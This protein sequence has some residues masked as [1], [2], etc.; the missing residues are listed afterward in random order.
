MT[1]NNLT[2]G[3]VGAGQMGRG[4][5]QVCAMAGMTVLLNDVS[6]QAVARGIDT[7][8]GQLD[9]LVTK[10]KLSASA[11][12]EALRHLKP[13]ASLEQLAQCD[14]VIEAATE[15][16]ALKLDI[17]RRLDAIVQPNAVLASNTSSIS[18]TRIAAATQRP[19]KVIGMHFMNP[20]PVMPLIEV[21][22]GLHTSDAVCQAVTLLAKQIGKVPVEVKDGFGFVANRLLIPM[23]NEAIFCLHEG[24]ASAEDIDTVMKLGANHPI[25]PLA[26]ADLIG[27]DTCLAIMAVLHEGF[28]DSKYRPCPLLKQMVDAGLLG[29]KTGQGFF[30]YN[31]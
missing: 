17:F 28:D 20:V 22:R 18:I 7:I 6:E 13:A 15:N 5:A 23:I 9:R 14:C 30:R 24:L 12:D 4:I 8:A 29:R 10:D 1:D 2:I 21:I 27:L 31:T 16:E 3:V 25:G 19:D 11:R 26:L